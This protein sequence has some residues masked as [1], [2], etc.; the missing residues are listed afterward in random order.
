MA[1]AKALGMVG[2]VLGG[3]TALAMLM[4]LFA[5]KSHLDGRTSFDAPQALIAGFS[6]AR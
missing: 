4:A 2:F 6:A 5:V 3:V 1:D